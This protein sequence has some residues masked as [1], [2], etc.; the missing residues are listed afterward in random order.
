MAS[1]PGSA[2]EAL[3]AR[4]RCQSRGRLR[5]EGRG[6]GD[7]IAACRGPGGYEQEGNGA[8]RRDEKGEGGSEGEGTRRSGGD[9]RAPRT[10]P[11][12]GG[13]AASVA[14]DLF[15]VEDPARGAR[16]RP[17]G[18]EGDQEGED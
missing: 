14:E 16:G 9:G 11:A 2:A 18:F 7:F 8:L 12:A 4:R 10:P 5:R 3:A 13:A 17:E 1:A 15:T 6:F